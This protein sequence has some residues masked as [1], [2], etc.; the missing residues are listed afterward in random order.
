M[1]LF[2]LAI[3]FAF[4]GNALLGSLVVATSWRRAA[5][6]GFGVLSLLIAYYLACFWGGANAYTPE[7]AE[8]WIRMCNTAGLMLPLGFEILRHSIVSGKTVFRGNRYLMRWVLFMMPFAALCFTRFFMI[9]ASLPSGTGTVS[10]PNYGPGFLLYPLYFI[11][12]TGCFIRRFVKDLRESTGVRSLELQFVALGT[13]SILVYGIVLLLLTM[14][15]GTIESAR[16]LPVGII[17]LDAFIAYGIATRRI[18]GVSYV[19]QRVTAYATLAVYLGVGYSLCWKVV[20]VT[21]HLMGIVERFPYAH[22]I[23]TIVIA[24][25]LVPAKGWSQSFARLL[26][27]SSP[28]TSIDDT[29]EKANHLLQFVT[30]TDVLFE[31]FSRVIV[32]DL[33]TG[34]VTVLIANAASG[35]YE[36]NYPAV[37]SNGGGLAI[38]EDSVLAKSL[39]ASRDPMVLDFLDRAR[40]GIG[41]TEV[42]KAMSDLSVAVAIGIHTRE[43]LAGIVLLG[44]RVS[45]RVYDAIEQRALQLISDQLGVALENAQLYTA[46]QDSNIYNDLIVNSLVSGLIATDPDGRVT[47]MN[48]KAQEITGIDA[49]RVSDSSASDLPE[50]LAA[51]FADTISNGAKI[52]DRDVVIATKDGEEVPVRISTSVFYGHE[53]IARG[54]LALISDMTE[55]RKLEEQV[56]RKDRLSSLG[57][58]SAGMAHEIKNPLVSI[59][60][61]TQ[62]LPDRYNDEE[63]RSTFFDL[64]GREITRID[65]IVNRLLRF[66]R[67]AKASLHLMN[68][69]GALNESLQLMHEQAKS[70][71]VALR[72][73]FSADASSIKGDSEL[74]KQA[75]INFFLNSI[76]AMPRGGELLVKTE[77]RPSAHGSMFEPE[78]AADEVLSVVISDTGIGMRPDD[79][80]HVFDPFFTKKSNGT[81]LGLSVAHSILQE[82]NAAIHVESRLGEGTTFSIMFPVARREGVAA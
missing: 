18:M 22:F 8:F 55:L 31:Q 43:G 13:G 3:A 73:D 51:I 40:S 78:V 56:R 6:R 28:T 11:V 53:G 45:G 65:S 52:R 82:H 19:M 64:I 27:I 46:L 4:V 72:T 71:N 12:S 29:I 60:T 77:C 34:P 79:V 2:K 36:Q 17:F 20:D 68:V 24:L 30:H 76:E 69:Q 67:P 74:L 38:D 57:T 66:A 21:T 54:A 7:S 61:F 59:K 42:G 50:P 70:R 81:G 15:T 1:N 5:A 58:L 37:S 49:E 48:Q 23:A 9:S 39:V 80:K 32:Q 75:F 10:V 41:V 44:E 62:L 35:R 33:R 14:I 47:V 16:F 25:S 26:F 63:F